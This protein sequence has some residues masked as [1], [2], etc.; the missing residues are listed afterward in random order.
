VYFLSATALAGVAVAI[1]AYTVF[2]SATGMNL[3]RLSTVLAVLAVVG[4]L[5]AMLSAPDPHWWK[6]HLSALGMSNSV[7]S[8]TF[9]IT[10]IVAG[11]VMA[12]IARYATD[13]RDIDEPSRKAAAK[14]IRVGLILIG[15]LLALVG[16]FPLDVSPIVHNVSAVGMLVTFSLVVF[17]VHKA[18]P[19]AP[20]SFFV[21]GYLGFA[22][23]VLMVVFF[24]IGYYVLTATELVAG[25]IIFGWLV[26]YLRVS[27]AG[28][29]A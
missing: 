6:L 12:A 9:N 2:L 29:R 18:L 21:F 7:S 15:V 28:E 4:L 8:L 25:G 24:V 19:S 26:V 3:M 16:A 13:V 23:I 17:W 5:A 22:V 10:L 14:R 20:R 11:L 27:G 1:S